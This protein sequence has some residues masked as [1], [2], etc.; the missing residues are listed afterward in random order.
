V[1]P[2]SP[3]AL[4]RV[5]Y[6]WE[7]LNLDNNKVYRKIGDSKFRPVGTVKAP[8]FVDQKSPSGDVTYTVT[9]VNVYDAESSHAKPAAKSKP[10]AQD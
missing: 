2:A 5:N 3:Q 10:P 6:H 8:P 7:P 1:A 4:Q 9:A